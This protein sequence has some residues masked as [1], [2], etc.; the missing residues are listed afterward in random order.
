MASTL[1][2]ND[3][4]KHIDPFDLEKKRYFRE[5]TNEGKVYLS[6]SYS[7]A[8]DIIDYLI[9]GLRSAMSYTGAKNLKEFE[10]KAIAGVQTAAAFEEG[11]AV[12]KWQY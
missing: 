7:G 10:E 2:V 1:A 4:F 11:L 3:K 6:E 12:K 8:E 9:S 5:G